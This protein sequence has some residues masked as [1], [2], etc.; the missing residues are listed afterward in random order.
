MKRILCVDDHKDIC[1]LVVAL[2]PDYEIF[3]EHTAIEAVMR[4]ATFSFD[5]YLIEYLLPDAD[6]IFLCEAIRRFDPSVPILL[7]NGTGLI[8][9]RQVVE[10]GAQGLI[11]KETGFPSNL[12][13]EIKRLVSI[14][15]I[16]TP[17]AIVIF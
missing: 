11:K 8:T 5:L 14:V 9:E 16:A 6:G 12:V 13:E 7:F 2:L 1:E 15:F 10:A 17:L 3:C 4:A